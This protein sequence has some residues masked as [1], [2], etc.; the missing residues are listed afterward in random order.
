MSTK[1]KCKLYDF[2]DYRVKHTLY[3]T[4][5]AGINT[6]KIEVEI[7]DKVITFKTNTDY[8]WI[9]Q[10]CDTHEVFLATSSQLEDIYFYGN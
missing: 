3:A 1:Y 9:V 8:F 5:M 6:P 7:L 4:Y 2:F 10:N